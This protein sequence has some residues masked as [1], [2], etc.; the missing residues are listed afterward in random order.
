MG[1]IT[2][3]IA[4]VLTLFYVQLSLHVIRLRKLHQVS[5]GTGGVE[6]LERAIRAHG[7]F[8]E[9]VPLSL[10]LMA[11]LE[12]NGAPSLLVAALGACLVMGRYLHAKGMRDSD[13][14]MPVKEGHISRVLLVLD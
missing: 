10:V 3:L 2:A 13:H 11:L 4:S 9:Y 14:G 1:Y 7:N 6:V 8:A 5:V 12:I